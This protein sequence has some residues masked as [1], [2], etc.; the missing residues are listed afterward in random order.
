MYK[1]IYTNLQPSTTF[2]LFSFGLKNVSAE[3]F[4]EIAQQNK[5]RGPKIDPVTVVTTL[6]GEVMN[7]E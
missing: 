4:L 5:A 6:Q 2:E 3:T 1:Y 7:Y